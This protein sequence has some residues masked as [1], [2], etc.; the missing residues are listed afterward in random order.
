MALVYSRF[1][2]RRLGLAK[3]A[4]STKGNVGNR[5]VSSHAELI[6]KER[7][8][9]SS[10]TV[11]SIKPFMLCL[12]KNHGTHGRLRLEP[13]KN[14]QEKFVRWAADYTWEQHIEELKKIYA[15]Q[16]SNLRPPVPE[17]GALSTELQAHKKILA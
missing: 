2:L 4:Y 13:A 17:T 1:R 9:T 15:W 12:Q 6:E 11:R 14:R 16:G 10:L 7:L 8:I 5:A 3:V